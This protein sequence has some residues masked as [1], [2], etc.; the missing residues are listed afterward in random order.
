MG[1]FPSITIN[2]FLGMNTS[3]DELSL[4][5]GQLSENQNYLYMTNG[6]LEERGGGA[7][8]SNSPDGSGKVYSLDNY[9][10]ENDQEFLIT[11]QGTDAYYYSSGWNA[12]SLTLTASKKMRWAQSGKGSAI[13]LY[14]VNGNDSVTKISGVTPT[15]S[16]VANSPTTGKYIA[17]HKNRVFIADDTTLYFSE[18]LDYDDYRLGTNDIDIAPG[19]NGKITG[20]EVW[21]DALFI[22]KEQGVYVLPNADL[23]TPKLNWVILKTDALTGT[24]SPDSVKRTKAGIF[25]LSSDNFVRLLSPNISYSSGDYTLGGSGSPIIS[26]DIQN[27]LDILLSRPSIPNAYAHVFND[28]YILSFESTNNAETFNDLTYFADSARFIQQPAIVQAQPFWGTFKGFD[29]DFMTSQVDDG[30]VKFYG[31]K[32]ETGQTHESMNE[33]IHND[34]GAAIESKAVLGWYP[35]GDE[36]TYSKVNRIYFVGDT[37]NWAIDLTFDSYE[38]GDIVPSTGVGT[39]YQTS[40]ST[41]STVGTAVVGTDIVGELTVGSDKFRANLRG[42]KFRAEMSNFNANE[43]TRILK[44][45]FYYRP[46]RS[47]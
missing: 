11:N 26:E 42:N 22:F 19:F 32:G 10:N 43:F 12:L 30:R 44:I 16:V 29:Y 27:D 40:T 25:Y 28:L 24:L 17:V 34:N 41:T 31:A 21:G 39:S 1:S 23:P 33:T 15:G 2:K 14:G 6:G 35:I 45:I 13:A 37:E 18:A 7:K 3:R 4:L 9:T 46:I 5:P 38:Y 8:L 47:H 20:L 36:A